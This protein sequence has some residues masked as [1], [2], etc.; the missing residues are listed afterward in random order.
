MG[1]YPS[2]Y[3]KR[4]NFEENLSCAGCR[5]FLL[6]SFVALSINLCYLVHK[7][8]YPT[9]YGLRKNF[10]LVYIAEGIVPQGK[11]DY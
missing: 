4:I 3:S 10:R 1:S 8:F 2:S 9:I 6:S 7:P 5:S 11:N